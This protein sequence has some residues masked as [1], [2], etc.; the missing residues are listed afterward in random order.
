VEN[1]TN[2]PSDLRLS[3][4]ER[5]S[6]IA[7][8][9]LSI[10]VLL[11]VVALRMPRSD[12]GHWAEVL[13]NLG[14]FT[15]SMLGSAAAI[16]WWWLKGSA[17]PRLKVTQSVDILPSANGY[18]PIY[19]T[20][21]LEN[22]GEVPLELNKWCLWATNMLPFPSDVDRLLNSEPD[23]ACRDYRLPWRACAGAEF[24]ISTKDAPRV[25]PGE[26]QDIGA[27]L[28][29]PAGGTFVR[30]YSFL[31][32]NSLSAEERSRGWVSITIVNLGKEGQ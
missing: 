16:W 31:P 30:I 20:A 14:Q 27:L 18:I 4:D 24:E 25:R 7:L 13:K 1:S 15:V 9:I 6:V 21:H 12:L 2:S 10:V 3:K 29:V 23:R 26:S 22:V 32:H 11:T 19:V 17:S 28:R 8:A 5:Q